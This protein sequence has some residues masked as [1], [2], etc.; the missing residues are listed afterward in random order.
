[1]IHIECVPAAYSA[2]VGI[3][4][5]PTRRIALVGPR[6][7][8]WRECMSGLRRG[9]GLPRARF[10]PVPAQAIALLA[11]I[12]NLLPGALLDTAAWQMLRRGNSA[13]VAPLRSL[14]GR[15]PRD[16]S[17]L[18]EPACAPALRALAPLRWWLPVARLSLARWSF[19]AGVRSLGGYPGQASAGLL[20][21]AGVPRARQPLALQLACWLDIALGGLVLM[22]RRLRWVWAAQ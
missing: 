2:P 10:V 17:R 20:V 19:L 13:D 11:R 21:R 18:I 14:L 5:M 12:G 8:S 1:P 15:L 16:V 3:A 9:M 22:A 4:R 6:A 7:L